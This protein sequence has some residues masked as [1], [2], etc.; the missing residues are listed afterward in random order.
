VHRVKGRSR[1]W[2]NNTRCRP[3]SASP[4]F[5]ARNKPTV[6]TGFD[7][8][9]SSD[10]CPVLGLMVWS[11]A[12][13]PCDGGGGSIAIVTAPSAIVATTSM[14]VP[15]PMPVILVSVGGSGGIIIGPSLI[16]VLEVSM[17]PIFKLW[18]LPSVPTIVSFETILQTIQF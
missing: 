5:I 1:P 9:N 7:G 14:E 17:K 11:K 16:V 4:A 2:K 15:P 13:V 18:S 6:V 3:R 12:A 10:L 8:Y